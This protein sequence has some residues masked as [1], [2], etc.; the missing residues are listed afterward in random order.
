MDKAKETVCV[1][2][3]G[4]KI[5]YYI[6]E[7]KRTVVAVMDGVR[8]EIMDEVWQYA[9]NKEYYSD[10]HKKVMLKDLYRGKA[11]CHESDEW[12]VEVGKKIARNRMLTNFYA[13]RYK[14][15]TW[16]ESYLIRIVNKISKKA[17]VADSC[18]SGSLDE[19]RQ[20]EI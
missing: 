10:F 12:D 9:P 8:D 2:Q 5:R 4:S 19:K 6:N 20:S 13:D 17:D 1:S 7:E 11:I 3:E 15:L 16:F 18:V 14:A